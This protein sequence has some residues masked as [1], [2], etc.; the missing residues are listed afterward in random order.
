MEVWWKEEGVMGCTFRKAPIAPRN[1]SCLRNR[2]AISPCIGKKSNHKS[3][4]KGNCRW[5]KKEN[6]EAARFRSRS[7]AP[8]APRDPACRKNRAVTSPCSIL[9]VRFSNLQIGCKTWQDSFE[10]AA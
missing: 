4:E 3:S 2:A 5:K 7:Q 6:E 8:V 10:T 1:P 9:Y